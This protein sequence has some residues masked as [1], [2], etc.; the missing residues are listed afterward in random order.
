MQVRYGILGHVWSKQSL[1]ASSNRALGKEGAIWIGF[2]LH[3]FLVWNI[4]LF[5]EM[6]SRSSMWSSKSLINPQRRIL[7]ASCTKIGKDKVSNKKMIIYQRDNFLDT[8][9]LLFAQLFKGQGMFTK[10]LFWDFS[11]LP[12]R[13]SWSHPLVRNWDM[14]CKGQEQREPQIDDWRTDEAFVK[15]FLEGVNPL[16]GH[17]W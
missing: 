9:S 10:R 1:A 16:V 5:K 3:H 13:F 14:K 11:V 8:L 7:H 4:F 12:H 17:H 15:H 6:F 2:L